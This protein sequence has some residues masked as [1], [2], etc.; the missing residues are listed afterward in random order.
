MEVP[1]WKAKYGNHP[2]NKLTGSVEEEVAPDFAFGLLN[3]EE[4]YNWPNPATDETRL[5]FQLSEPGEINVRIATMSGRQIYNRTI[6]SAGGAPEEIFIDTSTWSSGGYYA[7]VTA[8]ANG[9][10][11]R[12]MVK[13]GIIR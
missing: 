1:L 13:I 5:R 9:R 3:R 4:T 11:E 12:K 10:M 2:W 8:R 7:V 6:E